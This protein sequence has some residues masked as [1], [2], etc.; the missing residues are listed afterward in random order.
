MHSPLLLPSSLLLRSRRNY[1]TRCPL[2]QFAR[3]SC[4]HLFF[5]PYFHSLRAHA[6]FLP[7]STHISIHSPS[8][9]IFAV[10]VVV[11]L[12]YLSYKPLI[13][14]TNTS[15]VNATLSNIHSDCILL[16]AAAC[17][18]LLLKRREIRWRVRSFLNERERAEKMQYEH[19]ER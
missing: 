8:L 4:L 14:S 16:C 1:A 2:R 15:S 11:V 7:F 13:P 19:R 18:S 6:F 17:C 9:C 12:Q 3:L 10:M 5:L